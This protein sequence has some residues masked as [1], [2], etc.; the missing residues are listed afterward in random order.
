M[1]SLEGKCKQCWR[2]SSSSAAVSGSVT[3]LLPL[4]LVLYSSSSLFISLSVTCLSSH[5]FISPYFPVYNFQQYFHSLLPFLRFSLLLLS[6]LYTFF[7]PF[8]LSPFPPLFRPFSSSVSPLLHLFPL[9]S[10]LFLPFY[11]SFSLHLFTLCSFPPRS[12]SSSPPL[13]FFSFSFS[14]PSLSHHRARL[15]QIT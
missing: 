9:L 3:L 8:F 5:L 2:P 6:F 7:F 11:I 12:P 15:P 4:S 14:P 13:P 1:N 10:P